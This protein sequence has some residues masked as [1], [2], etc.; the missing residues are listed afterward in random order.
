MGEKSRKALWVPFAR[1][2]ALCLALGAG[3]LSAQGLQAQTPTA[4]SSVTWRDMSE[5]HLNG[6]TLLPEPD[7]VRFTLAA[8]QAGSAWAPCKVD[9]RYDFFYEFSVYVGSSPADADGIAFVLHNDPKGFQALGRNG[10]GIGYGDLNETLNYDPWTSIQPSLAMEI[11]TNFNDEM[12]PDGDIPADHLA[13]VEN[14]WLE[15]P[16]AAGPVSAAPNAADGLI[17]DGKEHS[18]TMRWDAATHTLVLALDTGAALTYTNDIVQN[19]FGGESQ[20]YWGMTGATGVGFAPQYF[21]LKHYTCAFTSTP[22]ATETFTATPTATLTPT[23]TPTETLTVTP[24][25]TFTATWT[26]T[27]TP[28]STL[29]STW[30]P[31]GTPTATET[32]SF[33]SSPTPSSTPT[34]TSTSTTTPT[35]TTYVRIEKSVSNDA[36]MPGETVRYDLVAEVIGASVAAVTLTDDLPLGLDLSTLRFLSAPTPTL[37][38]RRLT[39]PLGVLP[40][41]STRVSF[42]VALDPAVQGGDPLRNCASALCAGTSSSESCAAV[43]VKGDVRV[44]VSVYNEAGERVATLGEVRTSAPIE[45]VE[46]SEDAV[47]NRLGDRVT[48]LWGESRRVLGVW[49]GLGEKGQPVMN[50]AY[51]LKIDNVD[52]FGSV[53]SVTRSLTVNRPLARVVVRVYNEAGETVRTLLGVVCDPLEGVA[54]LRLSTEVIEPGEGEGARSRVEIILAGDVQL[55]WDGRSNSGAYVVAG[56]YFVEL[57]VEGARGTQVVTRPLSVISSRGLTGMASLRPNVLGS[58]HPTA[59]VHVEGLRPEQRV[60][61]RVHN[62]AGHRVAEQEG[63][64]GQNDIVWNVKGLSSGLYIVR[65]DCMDGKGMLHQNVL[66]ALIQR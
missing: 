28:T 19:L 36:P 63:A 54:E 59:V 39:W 62:L 6:N 34:V 31:T 60:R 52:A 33:T 12:Q 61:F 9:L 29:T 11:D 55:E 40:S 15:Y 38:G 50:G 37:S 8:G 66:K 51:F 25:G 22:T 48:I 46:F 53:T 44:T 10:G 58:Q 13:V 35:A 23:R 47:L 5:W 41:G 64:M 65:V 57:T 21:R 18:M 24:T 2:F 56:A 16:V 4:T 32:P 42:E 17:T 1:R 30:T 45:R 3:F 26:P 43:T 14:G 20:V 49:D 27:G 7:I